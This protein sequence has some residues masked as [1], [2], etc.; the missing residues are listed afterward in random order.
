MRIWWAQLAQ[1]RT[2]LRQAREQWRAQLTRLLDTW[3]AYKSRDI[4]HPF[5]D[6]QDLLDMNGFFRRAA[7]APCVQPKAQTSSRQPR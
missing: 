1:A 2:S 3:S 4:T 7:C 6:L 5:E